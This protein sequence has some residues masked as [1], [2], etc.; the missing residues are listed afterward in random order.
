M[1]ATAFALRTMVLGRI[2]GKSLSEESLAFHSRTVLNF[3][4]IPTLL[5]LAFTLEL[6][7]IH[8]RVRRTVLVCF[9]LMATLVGADPFES[10]KT[11][12]DQLNG[13]TP[14]EF[15][16]LVVAAQ[17]GSASAQTLL[18]V[19]YLKG[20]RVEKNE[21]S[22][23]D[24][25]AKAAKKRQK[26]ALNNLGLLYFF[27]EGTAKNYPEAVRCFRGASE[28]GSVD[29]QFNLALMYH[30]GYGVPVDMSEAAKWY[31]IAARQ[32][33][34]RAQNILATLYENGDGVAKDAD[35][36]IDWFKKAA[37]SGYAMAQFNLGVHYVGTQEYPAAIHWFLLA[38]K[39]GHREATRNLI[40]LYLHGDADKLNYREAYRWLVSTHASDEWS[41]EKLQLCR[42]H[43]SPTD[44]N[45][46]DTTAALAPPE[47]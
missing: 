10:E 25:F 45:E 9:L 12:L 42:Q 5:D 22:A 16:N 11:A 35:Q 21:K 44:L 37:E 15:K 38:A 30:H 7:V 24:L 19:A 33:D 29:A 6:P 1:L 23:F 27:G 20:V 39:Q 32:G 46:I 14:S 47:K 36:A 4:T 8:A 40:A 2:S 18:G 31:E 28:Q 13:M 43:L 3:A 26:V 17:R 34:V 41:T